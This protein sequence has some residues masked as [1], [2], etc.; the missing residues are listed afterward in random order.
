MHDLNVALAV[1]AALVLVFGLLSGFVRGH[2]RVLS[3]P[4]AAVML[5]M[6]VGPSGLD[7][8]RLHD[9]GNPLRLLEQVSRVALAVSVMATALRLPDG[10]FKQQW[11]AMVMILG[12][13]MILMW[14][15]TGGISYLL[16]DL[17]LLSALILGA[18]L[19]P[20]DP[21]VAGTIV[22]GE[23]A[24][25]NIAERVRYFLSG[26]AGANDGGAYPLVLIGILLLQRSPGEAVIHWLT[27]SLLWNVGG[28]ILLGAVIGYGAA[29]IQ[30]WSEA[31][32]FTEKTSITTVTLALSLFTLGAV[33]L[34]GSDGI[35]AVFVAGVVFRD[36]ADKRDEAAEESVQDA[37]NRLFGFPVFVFFGM[38][39]PW[40]DW[41]AHS[42]MALVFPIAVLLLRRLPMILLLHRW[43]PPLERRA[44]CLFAG[45]FGPIGVAAI[46]Y[47]T[48]AESKTQDEI[49]WILGS[50]VVLASVLAHGMTSTPF[51]D[52]YHRVTG[53]PKGCD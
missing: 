15:L 22:A 37:V 13:G 18:A 34:L 36:L 38:A 14:L 6:V 41:A 51:T 1:I 2:V 52:R 16:F 19:T 31:E 32:K 46:Y 7:L 11:R 27:V 30:R 5:G 21:V 49:Y 53:E 26:E 24:Q 4:L 42:W 48:M 47:A 17:S 3:E 25:R 44:D 50:L 8:L 43:I 12:P 45:W 39:L 29:R 35:L 28:A 40:E 23:V 9:W 33:K 10:Y 20:T